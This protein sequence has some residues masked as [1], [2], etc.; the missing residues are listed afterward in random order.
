MKMSADEIQALLSKAI[1]SAIGSEEPAAS[2]AAPATDTSKQISALSA[3]VAALAKAAATGF[4]KPKTMEEMVAEA[5]APITKQ[6]EEL[7]KDV[8]PEPE[9]VPLPK[10]AEEL[11]KMIADSVAA[12]LKPLKKSAAPKGEG[13]VELTD[14]QATELVK[15][16]SEDEVE[17]SEETTDLAGN[18]LSKSARKGRKAL[19][20]FF[21]NMLKSGEAAFG[22][23]ATEDD[24]S[25]DDA[26]DDDE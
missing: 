4:E 1:E 19:D 18:P 14:D 15:S 2:A 7:K 21:G 9:V 13:K 10:T 3:Q 6:L 23:N 20:D 11:Q 12:A 5:M 25:D 26:D 8:K 24:E 17:L 16:I 22:K